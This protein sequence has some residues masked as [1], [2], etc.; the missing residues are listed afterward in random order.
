M[1]GVDWQYGTEPGYLRELVDYWADEFDWRRQERRLNAFRQFQ[2]VVDG[3][4][5]AGAG[6]GCADRFS[7]VDEGHNTYAA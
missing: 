5:R 7:D 6:L 3:R 4:L 1:D 2:A